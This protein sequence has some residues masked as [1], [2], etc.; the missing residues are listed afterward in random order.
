MNRL[1]LWHT[2][3]AFTDY[4]WHLKFAIKNGHTFDVILF[5]K[6]TMEEGRGLTMYFLQCSNESDYPKLLFKFASV[7]FCT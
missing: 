1:F 4:I 6:L 3:L 7:T 5:G 2:I